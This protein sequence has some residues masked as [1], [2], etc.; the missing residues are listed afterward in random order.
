MTMLL[1]GTARLLD[2]ISLKSK[3]NFELN[4]LFQK[5]IALQQYAASIG[6]GSI[7]ADDLMNAP[8]SM[9]Q[10][11]SIFMAY[12]NQAGMTYA[13]QN[14]GVVLA[15]NQQMLAQMPSDAL[16]QQYQ[17]MVFKNLYDQQAEKFA[18]AET[19]RLNA[20]ETKIDQQVSQ[21]Q[22]ELSMLA[23]E[24]KKTQEVVNQAAKDSAPNYVA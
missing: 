9:F 4:S 18:Q 5:K 12:S 19:K 3:L 13:N 6:D 16:R 15:S 24:E 21:K 10:R 14:A 7:S 1:C 22:T 20:E 23:E 2:I 17:Q 8:P 11:M